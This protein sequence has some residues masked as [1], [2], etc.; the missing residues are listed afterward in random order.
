LVVL[1]SV[2]AL[3]IG[4]VAGFCDGTVGGWLFETIDGHTPE[5]GA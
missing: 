3:G 5:T 1:F 4:A 2:L